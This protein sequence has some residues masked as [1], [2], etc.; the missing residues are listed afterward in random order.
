M[1]SFDEKTHKTQRFIFHVAHVF[2]L[3]V[4]LLIIVALAIALF[5]TMDQ[6]LVLYEGGDFNYFLVSIFDIIIGVELLKMLCR[7]DLDSVV[8]VLLFAVA[9]GLII[10]HLPIHQT[11][12]GI[13]AIAVLF[14]IRKYLFIPFL[15]KTGS[16]SR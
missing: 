16:D 5:G 13:L 14:L 3:L 6:F 4:A 9:R 15:D 12:I 1:Q 7:H 11:F 2:E 8:E 10:E